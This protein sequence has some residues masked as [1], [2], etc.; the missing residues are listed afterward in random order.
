MR[1]FGARL[2]T[3]LSRSV[4]KKPLAFCAGIGV[5]G[6]ASSNATT[7]LVTSFVAGSGCSR[8][9]AGDCARYGSGRR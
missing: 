7:M 3:V 4:E 6:S 9:C 8:A 2:R 5:T 1:V